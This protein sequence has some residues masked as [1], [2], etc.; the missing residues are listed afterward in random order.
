M[1]DNY[2]LTL[3]VSRQVGGQGGSTRVSQLVVDGLDIILLLDPSGT[4]L[5][6]SAAIL[7]FLGLISDSAMCDGLTHLAVSILN[8]RVCRCDGQRFDRWRD[9]SRGHSLGRWGH[10]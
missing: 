7:G 4:C 8:G 9:L 10:H 3:M 5:R 6:S 2:L 1:S